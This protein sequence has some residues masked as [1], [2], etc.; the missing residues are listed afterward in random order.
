MDKL[1]PEYREVIVLTRI[2]GLS[3]E[4]V[5]KRLGKS[6]DAVRMLLSRA[7]VALSKSF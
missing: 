4:E 7:M 5:G 1:K 3:Q 6:A 2:E